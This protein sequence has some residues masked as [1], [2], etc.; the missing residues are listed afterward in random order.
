MFSP[1]GCL[2]VLQFM[3][4]TMCWMCGKYC[5]ILP[6]YTL[7]ILLFIFLPFL[8]LPSNFLFHIK[9]VDIMFQLGSDWLHLNPSGSVHLFGINAGDSG[10]VWLVLIWLIS[11]KRLSTGLPWPLFPQ[12]VIQCQCLFGYYPLDTSRVE[13]TTTHT[14]THSQKWERMVKWVYMWKYQTK[15]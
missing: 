5:I 4:S 6:C 14:H 7:F 11:N 3:G 12:M 2:E 10:C 1:V 9:L 13:T 8:Y 15:V